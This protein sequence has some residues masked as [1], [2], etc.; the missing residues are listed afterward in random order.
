M[1]TLAPETVDFVTRLAGSERY[2][3]Y[4]RDTLVDLCA[5]NTAPDHDLAATAA[6]ERELFDRIEREVEAFPGGKV[7]VERPPVNPAIESDPAYTPPG[8]AADLRG[9]VP[10][11]GQAY[12]GRTNM[13]VMVSGDDDRASVVQHAH[14]DVVPP[15]T[16]PRVEEGRVVGRGAC[17]NKAQAAVMLAQMRLLDELQQHLGHQARCGRVYQFVIDEE[18]GGNGSLSL[19][20]DPRFAGSRMIVQE[21]TDLVPYCAHRGCVYYRCR[22]SA[23]RSAGGGAF[24]MFP[25][26]VTAM[27]EEGRRFQVE[28]RH[29]LFGVEHVQAN[30]GLLGCYGTTP[31]TVCDHVAVV[32]TAG[33]QT[34]LQE[35]AAKIEQCLAD[36][37][38]AYCRLHGDKR[39]ER[40][41]ATGRPRLER[42]FSVECVSRSDPTEFR[43]DVF[44]ISGHMGALSEC[45]NAIT[46]AA[47]MLR[48]IPDVSDSLFGDATIRPGDANEAGVEVVLEGGQGFTPC[49][50]MENVKARLLAAARRGVQEYCGIRGYRFDEGMIEMTFDRLHNDA[51]AADP[52]IE[53]MQSLLAAREAVGLP[54]IEVV[55]WR[56]SCDA[57]LYHARGYPAAIFGAGRLD[58]A[59]S[60]HEY[61]DIADMQ[62]ALAVS[63]LAVWAMIG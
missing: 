24:G 42:H 26:V 31:G 13:L 50:R 16:P 4:L 48:G 21:S 60:D 36:S 61:V 40:D 22:L 45:D 14:I 5:V 41:A 27:D 55:G 23:G 51:Y 8:Y 59:H 35:V 29:P 33:E 37:L 57:R 11:A 19:A 43:V 17:D 12:A 25:Y 44:G 62:K 54:P 9:H 7:K 49:H 20:M 6:R 38:K 28:T 46:K 10:S 47:Y 2:A 56:T 15:W 1:R 32:L 18:I 52:G 39:A 3:A 63:T 34:N 58:V 30:P 53:P